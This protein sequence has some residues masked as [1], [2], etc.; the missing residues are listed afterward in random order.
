MTGSVLFRRTEPFILNEWVCPPHTTKRAPT[1]SI[2]GFPGLSAAGTSAIDPLRS[3]GLWGGVFMGWSW[4]RQTL[5]CAG[6][7]HTGCLSTSSLVCYTLLDWFWSPPSI[8]AGLLFSPFAQ[9]LKKWKWKQM[10]SQNELK[11]IW[12]IKQTSFGI[13]PMIFK[14]RNVIHL[15]V[16]CCVN[17]VFLLLLWLCCCCC[18][19]CQDLMRLS[20]LIK[21]RVK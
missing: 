12:I 6:C 20:C 9:N 8:W 19:L 13:Y 3:G 21:V 11:V 1:K 18:S 2:W 7:S 16:Y 15:H 5:C 17:L 14:I 10:K 4:T